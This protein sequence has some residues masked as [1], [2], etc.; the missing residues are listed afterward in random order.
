MG[1]IR[2]IFSSIKAPYSVILKLN[3]RLTLIEEAIGRL[4]SR[5]LSQIDSP[6]LQENEFKV[7]SQWGDDGIIQYLVNQLD[8]PNKTFVE[9]GVENYTEAN[10][11]F[12]LVNNNW[13]GLVM[14][15]SSENI[16][17]I[18]NDAIYWQ[19]DLQATHAFIDVENV[20]ELIASSGFPNELGLLHIDI[21]G[22]DYWVW[23]AI[24]CVNPI[25]VIVEYNSL[26]GPFNSWAT[27]YDPAF[28]RSKFH[29]SSLCYGSSITSLCDLAEEKGYYFVGS[30]SAG[31]NAY[32]IRKDKIS[33]IKPLSA[34][35]GYVLSKFK[36]CRDEKGNL[37]FIRAD[38]RLEMIKGMEIYDTRLK[39]LVELV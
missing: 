10:T 39:R 13:S 38:Q 36:E 37:T 11:R 18:K 23:K 4:E 15:G 21:D 19:H 35:E 33:N 30:N 17:Y 20:N 2:R 6:S 26:F 31:N 8:I 14:D 28:V 29:H 9:F 24:K 1:F 7:F 16:S 5:Q 34:S 32:F 12:L 22:N 3:H 27:P 25:I